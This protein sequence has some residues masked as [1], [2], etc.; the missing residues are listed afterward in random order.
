EQLNTLSSAAGLL[1]TSND[2]VP[3]RIEKLQ[4]EVRQLHKDKESFQAKLSNQETEELIEKIEE[5]EGIQ[6]LAAEVKVKDMNQLRKMM[7]LI[8]QKKKSRINILLVENK[9][10]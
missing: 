1:K 6:K 4:E 2:N 10:Q 7:D 9:V 8:K 3:E 5:V